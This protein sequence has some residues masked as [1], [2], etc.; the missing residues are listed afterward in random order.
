MKL[1]WMLMAVPVFGAAAAALGGDLPASPDHP[2]VVAARGTAGCGCVP[3]PRWLLTAAR[4]GPQTTADPLRRGPHVPVPHRRGRKPM[5]S[6]TQR[7]GPPW[8]DPR[9]HPRAARLYLADL[10]TIHQVAIELGCCYS[11]ARQI[12]LDAGVKL[13]PVGGRSHAKALQHR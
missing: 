5:T 11:T 4:C 3:P 1:C 13:R 2:L 9:H 6:T 8:N 12:V 10:L 7:S